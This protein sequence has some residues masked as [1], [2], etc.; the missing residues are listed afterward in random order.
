MTRPGSRPG[1]G[2]CGRHLTRG[3][4]DWS[5][6][7]RLSHP[8]TTGSSIMWHLVEPVG[9]VMERQMLLGIRQRVERRRPPWPRMTGTPAEQPVRT[10]PGEDPEA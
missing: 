4:P 7:Q 1:S 9:F 3:G 8:P 2:S 6:R 5:A 10:T